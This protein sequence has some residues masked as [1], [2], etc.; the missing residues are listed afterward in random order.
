MKQV[1]FL[2]FSFLY[3]FSFGQ[4]FFSEGTVT[5]NV[6]SSVNG[7]T[8]SGEV[9]SVQS[10]KGS[11]TRIELMSAMGKT[12]T[13][14]DSRDGEGA[15][16]RDFGSQKIMIPITQEQLDNKNLK[17]KNIV[18]EYTNDTKQILNY[19]CQRAIASLADGT[20]V[21]VYFSKDLVT[22][23]TEIGFQF[24]KLPG[25]ALEFSSISSEATVT[26]KAVSVNFEPIPVQ[27]F[28]IPSSGYRILSY[29]ESQKRK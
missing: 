2:L 20:K 28:D 16:L 10:V 8:V 27:N 5:Y 15:I 7:K 4:K 6:L 3:S 23:N 19:Q 17:F 1:L 12:T 13:L 26:Y 18:F 14:F 21:E 9:K 29:E 25:L 22:E 24:G 11:H